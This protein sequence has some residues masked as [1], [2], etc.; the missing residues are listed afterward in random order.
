MEGI[1]LRGCLAQSGTPIAFQAVGGGTVRFD[2]DDS[3]VAGLAALLSYR[4]T[5]LLISIEPDPDGSL[6]QRRGRPKKV[7]DEQ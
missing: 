4:D 1:L 5:A 3:Q 7:A 6:I 2:F